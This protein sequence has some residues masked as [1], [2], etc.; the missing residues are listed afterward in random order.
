MF[1]NLLTGGTPSTG[2]GG[3]FSQSGPSIFQFQNHTPPTSSFDFKK[4]SD[5]ED[6]GDD[7]GVKE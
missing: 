7:E 4:E 3:L 2:S 6:D 5:G 1:S